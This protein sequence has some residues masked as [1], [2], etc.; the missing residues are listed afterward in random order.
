M[1]YENCENRQMMQLFQETPVRGGGGEPWPNYKC[2]QISVPCWTESCI[3]IAQCWNLIWSCLQFVYS[4]NSPD[5]NSPNSDMEFRKLFATRSLCN[6]PQLRSDEICL[7]TRQAVLPSFPPPKL[8]LP[9]VEIPVKKNKIVVAATQ[10]RSNLWKHKECGQGNNIE[11][12]GTPNSSSQ[13]V[14]LLVIKRMFVYC[15]WSDSQN[16]CLRWSCIIHRATLLGG[17]TFETEWHNMVT[18]L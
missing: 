13:M 15:V 9:V 2:C 6:H 10:E 16:I 5:A 4:A 3:I 18:E 17:N 12:Y 11:I 14:G 8:S 1:F 7:S